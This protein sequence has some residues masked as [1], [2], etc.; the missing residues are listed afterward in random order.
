MSGCSPLPSLIPAAKPAI[1]SRTSS[2]T[3]ASTKTRLPAEHTS[4]WLP[5]TPLLAPGTAAARSASANTMFGLLPP[6]SS[7]TRFN[8]SAQVRMMSFPISFEPV[9]LILSTRGW[10]RSGPPA[11]GPRPVTT[12]RTPGGRPASWTMRASSSAESGVCSAGLSTTVHPAASA[13]ATFWLA[14]SIG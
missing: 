14:I 10:V 3:A 2:Y 13:G 5:N 7:V 4:P 9:K 12:L 8:W 1:A 6:S 11:S